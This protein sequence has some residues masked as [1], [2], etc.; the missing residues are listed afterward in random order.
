MGAL[1]W[2]AIG[3]SAGVDWQMDPQSYEME[4]DADRA[5]R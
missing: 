2:P 3:G 5:F 1:F 4:P